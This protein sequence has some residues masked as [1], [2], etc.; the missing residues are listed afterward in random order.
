M[1]K[2]NKETKRWTTVEVID[3]TAGSAFDA[4]SEHVEIT[5]IL[6]HFRRLPGVKILSRNFL[7]R[8]AS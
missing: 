8:H 5:P 1:H 7:V 6:V 2:F 3:E 4:Q